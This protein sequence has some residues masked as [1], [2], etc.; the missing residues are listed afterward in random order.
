MTTQKSSLKEV[1][2]VVM[3][4]NSRANVLRSLEDEEKADLILKSL[5]DIKATLAS[6]LENL[7]KSLNTDVILQRLDYLESSFV[8]KSEVSAQTSE[9]RKAESTLN[10]K[11]LADQFD[12]LTKVIGK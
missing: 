9:T 12:R 2:C 10:Y 1:S 7:S 8:A 5:E 3:P 6:S 4:A 11:L